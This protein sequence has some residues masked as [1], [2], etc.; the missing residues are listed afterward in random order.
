MHTVRGRPSPF[1]ENQNPGSFE[2]LLLILCPSCASDAVELDL[3]GVCLSEMCPPFPQRE[4]AIHLVLVRGPDRSDRT[5][6]YLLG[7]PLKSVLDLLHE[8]V[9]GPQIP[10]AHGTKHHV[11]GCS[12]SRLARCHVVQLNHATW[13]GKAGD[14]S[15]GENMLLHR[16]L[17]GVPLLRLF[18]C[19][20]CHAFPCADP[21]LKG[22]PYQILNTTGGASWSAR[23]TP[24]ATEQHISRH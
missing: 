20:A 6:N 24:A 2:L 9:L 1:A 23:P 12:G 4:E 5:S 13:I 14:A 8:A 22:A 19:P 11:T 3:L 10:S 15:G 17:M 18:V 21:G 16:K 7:Q